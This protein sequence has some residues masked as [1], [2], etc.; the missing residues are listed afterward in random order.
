MEQSPSWEANCFATSQ[1]IPRV[2][3]NPKVP[4]R[5][6]KRPPPVPILSQ[7]NPVLTPTSHYLKIQRNIILPS[8]PRSPQRPLSLRVPHQNPVH[9]SPLPI[10]PT[11]PAHL[12]LLDFITR[13]ILGTEYRRFSSS[14]CNF[15]HSLFTSSLLGP[16]PVYV[17]SI[18]TILQNS[19]I[20]VSYFWNLVSD[21]IEKLK[22]ASFCRRCSNK[23]GQNLKLRRGCFSHT[24]SSLFFVSH[25][26]TW[27]HKSDTL[28]AS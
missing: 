13:T 27:Q 16:I 24:L 8:R 20:L 6:H 15:L 5:T 10:R 3:W 18:K 25:P 23:M 17:L 22:V 14:L 9:T 12:I 19:C 1:E 4:H 21:Q 11:C 7:P 28:T 2:L 26:I